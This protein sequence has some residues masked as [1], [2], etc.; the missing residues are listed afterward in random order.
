LLAAIP[1]IIAVVMVVTLAREVTPQNPVQ[2]PT[3]WRWRNLS[4]T[5]WWFIA[6]N[7]LYSLAHFTD[8]LFL[9]R[10]KDVVSP[11]M[12][13]REAEAFAVSVYFAYNIIYAAGATPMGGAIDRFGHRRGLIATYLIYAGAAAHFACAHA[14]WHVWVCFGMLALHRAS[15]HPA[16]RALVAELAA[17]EERGAAMG[18][19]H[20]TTGL[21]ALPASALAGLLWDKGDASLPFG[22]AA[23]LTLVAALLVWRRWERRH[24]HNP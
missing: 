20:G 12:T 18:V 19:Y 5:Y 11:S 23:V 7:A 24:P 10:A 16:S 3:A 22:A 2:K 9:L 13:Q 8:A 1:G 17:K 4:S 14:V 6:A 15:V 21:V